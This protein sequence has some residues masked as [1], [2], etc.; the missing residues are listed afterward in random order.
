MK[1]SLKILAIIL[2]ISGVLV[3]SGCTELGDKVSDHEVLGSKP[4][5]SSAPVSGPE[6]KVKSTYKDGFL[7]FE[8]MVAAKRSGGQSRSVLIIQGLNEEVAMN[9]SWDE[10]VKIGQ[11]NKSGAFYP[12]SSEQYKQLKVGQLVRMT[13]TQQEDTNPPLR[14]TQTMKIIKEPQLMQVTGFRDDIV[15]GY[16]LSIEMKENLIS[17][18]I[19][20]WVNRNNRGAIDSMMHSINIPYDGDTKLLDGLGQKLKVSELKVGDKLEIIPNKNWSYERMDDNNLQTQQVTRGTMTRSEK[21]K[22]MLARPGTIHTVVVYEEGAVPPKD[23]MDFGRYVPGAYSGGISWVPYRKG[24][25]IDYKEEL[26]VTTFPAFIVFDEE[27]AIYQTDSIRKL[28]KWFN[29][30][31]A[32][33]KGST[34]VE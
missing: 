21:L 30:R 15:T 2:G 11:K 16:V 14:N 22:Y 3:V 26:M 7:Y 20:D 29:D 12:V 19:S 18:N 23:E 13:S 5:V 10:L 6:P 9:S 17:L 34:A 31:A 25:A 33:A 32:A 1:A 28:Q 4:Q 27:D 24:E 8:G